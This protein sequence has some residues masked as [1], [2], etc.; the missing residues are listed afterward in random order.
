VHRLKNINEVKEVL[1]V[2]KPDIVGMDITSVEIYDDIKYSFNVTKVM[3]SSPTEINN[4]LSNLTML[5]ITNNAD[6]PAIA[7]AFAA[8]KYAG[9]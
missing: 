8:L 2:A 6:K 4:L 7:A 5:N 1:S 9:G 3:Q